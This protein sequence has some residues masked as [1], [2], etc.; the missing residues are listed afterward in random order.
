MDCPLCESGRVHLEEFALYGLDNFLS[1]KV[2]AEVC[3]TCREVFL[4]PGQIAATEVLR[5]DREF[6]GIPQG[7]AQA[8][9]IRPKE[10]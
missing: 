8:L 7:P 10:D 9:V 2:K 6:P 3:D 4:L 5:G 1:I